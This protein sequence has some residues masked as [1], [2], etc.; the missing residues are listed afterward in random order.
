MQ[1]HRE[2][3]GELQPSA[4]F[5]PASGLGQHGRVGFP[6]S[7]G[8]AGRGVLVEA[9]GC[10]GAGTRRWKD[11]W[12]NGRGLW[13]PQLSSCWVRKRG[14]LPSWE[15][16][17]SGKPEVGAAVALVPSN[18]MQCWASAAAVQKGLG[19]RSGPEESSHC[20]KRAASLPA[21]FPSCSCCSLLLS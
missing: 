14:R 18:L 12:G 1:F 7:G 11:A 5:L 10:A 15:P 19:T 17:G 4:S 16:H 13:C 20:Q 8:A 9:C 2:R 21:L 6:L 3:A